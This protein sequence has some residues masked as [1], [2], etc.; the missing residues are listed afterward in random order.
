MRTVSWGLVFVVF[1]TGPVAA[2]QDDTSERA[3]DQVTPET[4]IAIDRGLSWLA[5]RQNNDG[6]FGS[7]NN[8]GRNVAVS[9]LCGMA[10]L[11]S[12]STPGRGP[13]GEHVQKIVEFILSKSKPSGFII[14]ERYKSHGPMYGHGF[15][16]LFLAEVYGMT[17]D[18]EIREKLAKAV[19]LIVRTQ[20][21]EGGWRYQPAQVTAADVSVTVCQMM[22]LRAA[23]N[24]G[25]SVP[26]E[27]VDRCIGYVKRNQNPDGGFR[28]QLVRQAE[29]MFPRSA[30]CVVAMYNAGIFEG[31]EVT[32]GL[33]YLMRSLPRGEIFRYESYYYYGHY[34][35]VQAMWHAGGRYWNEWYAA[36][37]DEL[38]QK[39]LP[40]GSWSDTAICNEYATGMALIILQMPNNYLPIFQR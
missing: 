10:F 16:T 8:Y 37:R 39:Q 40:N 36:I 26:K 18:D 20:N 17:P 6:S 33:N 27:T 25:L 23:R 24:C 19:Q 5:S 12:G 7:G 31:P 21:R 38:L 13:Y 30:A 28:Y 32:R 3:V 11:S 15:A 35:A 1:A 29:S 22:A 9:S 4:Q 2:Q 14:N 34:Y